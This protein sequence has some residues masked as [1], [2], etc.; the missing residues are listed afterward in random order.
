MQAIAPRYDERKS[1]VGE[2]KFEPRTRFLTLP[3][4]QASGVPIGAGRRLRVS[5]TRGM[6]GSIDRVVRW[7]CHTSELRSEGGC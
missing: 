7:V 1:H 6:C 3:R 4:E 2:R 5:C